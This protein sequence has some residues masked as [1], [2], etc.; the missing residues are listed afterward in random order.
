[1][2]KLVGTG[3]NQ[4]PTNN[5]LGNM[6]FQ[7]KEGV[8]A[9]L[10]S[11]AAGTASAPSL[12][13]SGDT[14]TGMWF[15]AADTVAISTNGGERLRV[16]NSGY[17]GIGTASPLTFLHVRGGAGGIN[18]ILDSNSS[19]DTRIE[20]RNNATR[21]GY[22]YWDASEVRY[23]ADTSRFATFY[24]NAFERMRITSTGNVGIGISSPLSILHI[25]QTSDPE[26]RLQ[27]GT[28]SS[29]GR[30]GFYSSTLLDGSI[31]MVPQTAIL[32]ISS[33]RFAGWGGRISFVTDTSEKMRISSSGDIFIG[34]TATTSPIVFNKAIYLQ[35]ATNNDIIGCNF[36]INDG[37]NNRR[38]AMFLDDANGLFGWDV[39]ASSGVPDYVWRTASV[40]RMRITEAGNV[41][42]GT[43][44]S[45]GYKVVNYTAVGSA[46]SSGDTSSSYELISGAS[47]TGTSVVSSSYATTLVLQ[48]NTDTFSANTGASIGFQGKWN[49]SLYASAAQFS[50]IFGGKENGTD[51]NLAGY[52]SFATRPAGGN[53]TERMR[54]NS[55]GNVGI[56]TIAP[57]TKLHIVGTSGN[58]LIRLDDAINPRN[59]YIG[60]DN[61]EQVVLSAN[62]SNTVG[63]TPLIKFRINASEKAR[64]DASGNVGIGTTILAAQLTVNGSGGIF[65]VNG[66]NYATIS[67]LT[68]SADAVFGGG[69]IA[70]TG[71]SSQVKKT[72]ADPAHMIRMQ[73]SDGIA[74]HTNFTGAAGTSFARTANQRMSIDVNGN[75]VINTAAVA[76]T[77][78]NGF[79]YVPGCAGTPTGVPTAYAGRVPIVVDTTNNKLYFYSG[80]AWRDAGP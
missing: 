20:F 40:E 11:L 26:I 42:I 78:T 43:S 65:S 58:I 77:A 74:F 62:E 67:T 28:A 31:E 50:S 80:G 46:V 27:N 16:D 53:P 12:I 55:A 71:V 54:I 47:R 33:G 44:S 75:V 6:A 23:F 64:I 72:T 68:S 36:F 60:V 69:M 14:N 57:S 48:S 37:S 10:V 34:G 1:M 39:T 22:V 76:T 59:N 15:P 66:Y 73:I 29:T 18:S 7:N 17:V 35:S 49:S 8:S 56:G 38:A 52:L 24:T 3:G 5:M 61:Y 79:L 21:A 63:A 25:Q 2:V 19:S 30:L 51:A 32:T 4:V 45:T 41:L 70:D 9:D 13:P